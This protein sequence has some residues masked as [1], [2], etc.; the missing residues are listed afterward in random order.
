MIID[1]MTEIYKHPWFCASWLFPFSLKVHSINSE[2]SD[3]LGYCDDQVNFY[4]LPRT[5]F[6][7]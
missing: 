7:T 3:V 4:E 6:S 2:V 1:Y 5:L